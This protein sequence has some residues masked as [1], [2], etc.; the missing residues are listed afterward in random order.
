[1]KKDCD[2]QSEDDMEYN[3][4]V[5]PVKMQED[6]LDEYR[7]NIKSLHDMADQVKHVGQNTSKYLAEQ[8]EEAETEELKS[9]Y[10]QLADAA[11]LA[12]RRIQHGD[13]TI[14]RGGM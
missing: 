2:T 11:R 3:K 9:E 14:V 1:M 6:E 13:N 8:A 7:K 4:E 10:L 12:Y 5:D